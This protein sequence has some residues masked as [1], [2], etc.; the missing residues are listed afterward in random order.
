M[1]KRLLQQNSNSALQAFVVALVLLTQA[2]LVMHYPVHII[3]DASPAAVHVHARQHQD[4]A[5]HPSGDCPDHICPVCF[6]GDMLLKT[7]F[8]A[9]VLFLVARPEWFRLDVFFRRL[10]SPA[11]PHAFDA[12]A[13]PLRG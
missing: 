1:H 8:S 2:I 9:V 7:L 11:A 3:E 4:K 12:Q 5:G 6:V 10:I 13:P